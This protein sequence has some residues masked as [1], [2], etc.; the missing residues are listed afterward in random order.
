MLVLKTQFYN[1]PAIKF[2]LN[3]GFQLIGF[4]SATYTNDDITRKELRLEFGLPLTVL[5]RF[6][7]SCI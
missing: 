3:Y 2:Y 1:V 4:D 7:Q 5:I 6:S